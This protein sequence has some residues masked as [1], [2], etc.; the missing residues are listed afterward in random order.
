MRKGDGLRLLATLA[1]A[2]VLG[3]FAV[4]RTIGPVYDYRLRWTWVIGMV[5]FVAIVWCAALALSRWHRDAANR[6]L[7]AVALVG[8]AACT[9]VNV[10][11]A[12]T[13]GVPQHADV[14]VLAALLPRVL[15]TLSDDPNSRRRQVV[16]DDSPHELSAWYSRSLVLQLERRGYDARMPPPRGFV[17]GDHRQVDGGPVAV[18]LI[19][20]SDREIEQRDAD[21]ALHRI[22]KWSSVSLDEE[23]SFDQHAAA[24][25]RALVEGRISGLEHTIRLSQIDPANA[26]PAVAW[27]VAVYTVDPIR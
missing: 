20:A 16:V 23:R 25:D 10:T 15:D 12:A 13:A 5:A 21:P 17:V 26:D 22:A 14:K 18:H 7:V 2:F 9:V 24:L 1:I 27:A 19:F 8:L 6:V 11:T 3:I 4:D